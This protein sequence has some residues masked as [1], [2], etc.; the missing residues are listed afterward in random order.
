MFFNFKLTKKLVLSAALFFVC[1]CI[2][3][4]VGVTAGIAVSVHG[5]QEKTVQLPVIMYH[6]VLKDPS[7][8]GKYVVSP[9]VL[10]KDLQYLKATGIPVY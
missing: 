1:V 4:T 2:L 10:E 8:Q 7:Q 3:G 5:E 9:D 6:G